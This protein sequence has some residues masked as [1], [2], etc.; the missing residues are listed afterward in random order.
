M[1]G[2]NRVS[3]MIKWIGVI[4]LGIVILLAILFSFRK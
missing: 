4:V 1:S 2:L 3:K